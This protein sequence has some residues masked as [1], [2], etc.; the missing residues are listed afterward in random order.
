[1]RGLILALVLAGA[2]PAA[3]LQTDLS[4]SCDGVTISTSDACTAATDDYTLSSSASAWARTRDNVAEG[5]AG[6]DIIADGFLFPEDAFGAAQFRLGF[7]VTGPVRSGVARISASLRNDEFGGVMASSLF[8]QSGNRL[9]WNSC[10]TAT[11][12]DSQGLSCSYEYSLEVVLGTPMAIEAYAWAAPGGRYSFSTAQIAVAFYEAD[13]ITPAS[14]A[15]DPVSEVPEPAGVAL[16]AAAILTGAA[17]RIGS[18]RRRTNR[19]G[20][21]T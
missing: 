7:S 15:E 20:G 8:D 11:I 12:F 13:G 16:V 17:R 21:R 19:S 4:V 2:A 5:A 14:F 10:S 6:V 18:R 3:L 1:M 9:G